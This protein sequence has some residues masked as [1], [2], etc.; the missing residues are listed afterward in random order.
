MR[1]TCTYR[2]IVT[3]VAIWGQGSIFYADGEK[4]NISNP[5]VGLQL[6]KNKFL[7]FLWTCSV[8]QQF[9]FL[10]AFVLC[11]QC[12]LFRCT[13]EQRRQVFKF[14][15]A[16]EI[17]LFSM[18]N[19]TS[20]HIWPN[21]QNVPLRVAL[22]YYITEQSTYAKLLHPVLLC[23]CII[24]TKGCSSDSSAML[25]YFTLVRGKFFPVNKACCQSTIH[26]LHQLDDAFQ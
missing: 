2:L 25:L 13:D 18:N 22:Q 23:T 10:F 5:S 1:C 8:N 21:M 19:R 24:S 16:M 14:S 6:A 7:I 26:Y 20:H 3:E 17:T 12:S 4:S 11:L 9:F 15:C